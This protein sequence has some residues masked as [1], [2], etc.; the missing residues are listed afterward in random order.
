MREHAYNG[1]VVFERNIGTESNLKS[2]VYTVLAI[3][4]LAPAATAQD[5]PYFE[6]LSESEYQAK[7]TEFAAKDYLITDIQVTVRDNDARFDLSLE[8]PT[9]NP[10]LWY[11][12]HHMSDRVFRLQSKEYKNKGLELAVHRRYRLNRQS[13]HAAVWRDRPPTRLTVWD[14]Q[15]S[16]D[17]S[18]PENSDLQ[19]LDNLVQ[20]F[21]QD[22]Q[23]PGATLAVSRNGKLVYNRGFGYSEIVKKTKMQPDAMMRVASISKPI[24]ATAIMLLVEQQKLN[25]DDKVLDI[26]D[27][28]PS[29]NKKIADPRFHDITIEQ[30]LT[31]S[32][33]FDR[34]ASF[35]PMFKNRMIAKSMRVPS[36]PKPDQVIRYMLTRELDF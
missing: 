21:I 34:E 13:L 32:A 9:G 20:K 31:H 28:R 18:G 35:D 2:I 10:P 29:G 23:I 36:P 8:K 11:A 4:L 12:Q 6:Q 5:K 22:N 19:P 17:I 27:H 16:P 15:N 26:I 33:G 3:A 14:N 30:L 7:V 24:T 1:A 25:L